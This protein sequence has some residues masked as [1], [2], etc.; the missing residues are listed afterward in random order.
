MFGRIL[1]ILIFRRATYLEI[2]K[3]KSAIGQALILVVISSLLYGFIG[4]AVVA[5]YWAGAWPG[6]IAPVAGRGAIASFAPFISWI[7]VAVLLVL[8]SGLFKGKTTIGEML[9]VT[10]FVGG[11]FGIPALVLASVLASLGAASAMEAVVGVIAILEF[12]GYTIG[13]SEAAGITMRKAFIVALVAVFVGFFV[14][15]FFADL[16]IG[17]LKIPVAQAYFSPSTTTRML[18]SRMAE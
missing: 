1:G 8:V 2:A 14:V 9:R 15:I 10:A 18:R 4:A 16:I 6:K 12:G 5:G 7:I 11:V 3:D 13:V 17:L